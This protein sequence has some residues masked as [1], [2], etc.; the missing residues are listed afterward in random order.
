MSSPKKSVPMK[1]GI[2]RL[3]NIAK[4]GLQAIA[5]NK[6]RSLLTMLGIIIGVGCVITMLAV[7][8]GAS[9]SIQATINSLGT[10]FIMLFP[11]ASTQSGARVFTGESAITAADVE[12]IRQEAPAVAYVSPSVR[13]GAQVVAGD[14]NWGTSVYGVDVDWPF[15]RA[16]NVADG[17]FFSDVDVRTSGRVAV[18]GATVADNL[19]PAGDAVGSSIRIKNVPFRVV[20]VLDRKG[21]N[22]MGQDQDDQI[23][24]PYTTVMKQL[25][26]RQRIG[27][28]LISAA[29]AKEVAQ[30]QTEIDALLRQR[31]RIGP[32]QEADFTMRSQEEI[33][34]TSAQMS[35]TLSILL[36]SAAAISLLVGGIGI[37]N[38]ML[39]SVTE[40]TREIGIRLAIGAKGKHVLLQFLLEA[41]ALAI[42][43]GLIGVGLGVLAPYL[44][45]R[46][47]ELPTDV[48]SSSILLAFGFA[49]A[50]GIFFGYYP[51]R[52]ASRLDPIDA[53]R[54]E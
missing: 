33:A 15:I 22:M 37:M 18:L 53:L 32:G 35:K 10:N 14:L 16:W 54:Y 17:D 4:V 52:K 41:M 7:G 11:G 38:I 13:E 1:V 51:A 12:A 21:G 45:S 49:A 3:G 34:S 50:I 23:I 29:S 9:S 19:F 6:M 46:F 40:R 42:V 43:G 26:G 20:G 31:H 39:V 48:S 36:G 2:L 44:V 47:S 28:V 25:Q 30:A 5:R 27:Q 8:T 24:A